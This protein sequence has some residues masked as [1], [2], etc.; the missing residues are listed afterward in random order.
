MNKIVEKAAVESIDDYEID[1]L[2]LMH[3]IWKRR[4]LV[5]VCVAAFMVT[6][7]VYLRVATFVYTAQLQV[8]PAASSGNE[9]LSSS[10]NGLRGLA[11]LA[12]TVL[13]GNQQASSF[14]LYINSLHSR[15]V[16]E[17]LSRHEEIMSVVFSSEWDAVTKQWKMPTSTLTPL[18]NA[19]KKALGIPIYPWQPPG[20]GRLQEY[21][22][23]AIEIDQDPKSPIATIRMEHK[24]PTFA[25][26]FLAAAHNAAD[27]QLRRKALARASDYIRYLTGKLETVVVAEHRLVI[28]DALSE[29]EKVRMMTSSPSPFAAELFGQPSASLRATK[30]RPIVVL[31]GSVLIGVFVGALL[32]ALLS[33]RDARVN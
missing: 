24:D 7:L 29:Q 19:I 18:K 16:A 6:A 2:G 9:G 5:S 15:Q 25:T 1:L 11:S 14:D 33:I 22:E 20:A 32:V 12:G 28:A 21:M 26:R 17:E 23:N 27:G 8:T 3:S 4:L 13:P 30:P 10:L 31:L